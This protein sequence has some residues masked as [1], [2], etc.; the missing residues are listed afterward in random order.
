MSAFAVFDP[1][2]DGVGL[3]GWDTVQIAPGSPVCDWAFAAADEPVNKGGLANR[4]ALATGVRLRLET[5]RRC[6]A[7]HPLAKYAEGDRRGFWGEDLLEDGEKIVGSLLWLLDRSVA[8][9]EMRLYAD[10]FTREALADM[11]SGGECAR[12]DTAV[13]IVGTSAF[14][15][16]IALYGR[17]GAK[18]YDHRY[19]SAWLQAGL[20]GD[21]R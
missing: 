1:L 15:I 21:A 3:Y 6:P 14:A 13:E 17:D 12:I 9:E 19:E 2:C 5:D 7:D 18:L 16:G 10:L 20:A 4:A 11:I 8:S